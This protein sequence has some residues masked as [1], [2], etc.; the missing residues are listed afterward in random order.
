MPKKKKEIAN[1]KEQLPKGERFY[2]WLREWTDAFVFA[3]FLAMLIRTFVVELYKIP[4]G[5]M[6]PTLIGDWVAEQD[7]DKDGTKDLILVDH[8]SKHRGRVRWVFLKEGDHYKQP[9]IYVGHDYKYITGI[10][11]RNDR[12]LVNKLAYFF[13]KPKR[14][15]PIVF[16]VPQNIFD[17]N[18][19]Y[20]IKRLV[21]FGGERISIRDGHLYIDGEMVTKPEQIA[22]VY[23]MNMWNFYPPDSEIKI[24]EGEV[25]GFGDNSNNSLDS[26]RWGGIPYEN[27]KGK[28]FFRWWPPSKIGFIK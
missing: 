5:S 9:P 23:Y 26:R 7:W 3:F 16:K 12:I 18:K 24:P 14:G 11:E 8:I 20:F 1:E 10:K 4:T 6:T 22:R 13:K 25:Y 19:P 21:G 27:L 2:L 17:P 28:A 15:D